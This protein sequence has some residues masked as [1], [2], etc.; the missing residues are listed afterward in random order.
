MSQSS[1]R[2]SSKNLPTVT[3]VIPT[4]NERLHI[5][6]VVRGFSL[7]TYSQLIEILVADG[8]STDGTQEIVRE[9]SPLD[10]RIELL[11]NRDQIQSA[12]LNLAIEAARGEVILRADAHSEYAPDYLER[13]IEVL[14]ES[15]ALNVGGAQRHVAK[16]RFQAGVTLAVLSLLNG[17]AKYHN[18]DYDGWADTVYLGCFWKSAL[19]EVAIANPRGEVFDTTQVANQDAELNLRLVERSPQ[20]IYVSSKIQVWYYPRSTWRALYKQYFRY[21]RGRYLTA[22]KHPDSFPFR[23][24]IPFATLVGLGLALGLD[25]ILPIDLYVPQIIAG[26]ILLIFIEALRVTAKYSPDFEKE[27]WRGNQE[28][29]PSFLSRLYF[30]FLAL[31]TMP[32]AYSIGFTYQ[33]IRHRLLRVQGW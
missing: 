15:K 9:M 23:S 2:V 27:F 6:Q 29:S 24:K 16:N 14:L 1:L 28:D 4:Y 25:W 31:L 7:S 10:S 5:D 32:T 33:L 22:L 18:W 30:C 11:Y 8:G 13:C 12:G 3:V 20:A 17:G 21:G 26:I 19:L